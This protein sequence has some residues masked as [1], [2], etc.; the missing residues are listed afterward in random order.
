[1]DRELQLLKLV[2]SKDDHVRNFRC[3]IDAIVSMKMHQVD[4]V[5]A[6]GMATSAFLA[7]YSSLQQSLHSLYQDAPLTMLHHELGITST[8]RVVDQLQPTQSRLRSVIVGFFEQLSRKVVQFHKDESKTS[9]GE[10]LLAM[11]KAVYGIDIEHKGTPVADLVG[12]FKCGGGSSLQLKVQQILIRLAVAREVSPDIP[13]DGLDGSLV[14]RLRD[15]Y[16]IAAA[17]NS[18][19]RGTKHWKLHHMPTVGFEKDYIARFG[20]TKAVVPPQIV[21]NIERKQTVEEK[22]EAMT[23]EIEQLRAEAR[24]A[25]KASRV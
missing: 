10:T 3:S 16:T 14:L 5:H 9:M 25:D 2:Y 8:V 18:Y 13:E 24:V 4:T 19:V 23:R 21:Y 20:R 1:M 7:E 12:A 15:C 6:L 17:W 11:A 22:L